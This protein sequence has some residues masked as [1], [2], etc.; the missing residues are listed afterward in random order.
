MSLTTPTMH[1]AISI[2]AAIACVVVLATIRARHRLR[3]RRLPPG[4][5]PL[6]LIGNTHQVDPSYPWLSFTQWKAPYGDL[7]YCNVLGQD[8]VIVNSEKVAEDLMEKRSRN[9]SDRMDMSDM[10]EPYGMDF[11]TVLL[12]HNATWQ[13]H[14][15]ILQQT[16]RPEVV[17]AYQSTQLHCTA[18]LT[19]SLARAPS[20]WWK[21]IRSFSAAIVIGTIYDHELP[22]NPEHDVSFKA[23]LDGS[24]LGVIIASPGPVALVK[25]I[26]LVKQLPTWMPGGQ[27][28]NAAACK[29]VFNKMVG[30]PFDEL[31]G[32]IATGK[33]GPCVAA[34]ALAKFQDT[35]KLENAEQVVKD[36]CG[37]AYSAGEETT[38]STLI[39]FTLAMVLYPD[40]Q[41]RAQDEIESIVGSSR[42]PDFNDRSA[43]PYIEAVFR[44]TLRW[45]P[46]VPLAIPH[47]AANEDVY[48]GYL[49]PKGAVIMPNLWAMSQDSTKYPSPETFNPERFLDATG[50]LTTDTPNFAFGFGRRVCPGRH[51]ASGSVW[52]AIAQ[53]LAAFSIEKAKDA[54]GNVIE[55]NP[56]WKRG[57]S[58]Y[59]LPFPCSFVPRR[60]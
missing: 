15:R 27:W 36:V 13:A 40:I 7:V 37:T 59:P 9:Y 38:G 43:L 1:S 33:A 18:N 14:R 45:R 2:S 42:L 55:P 28:F 52:I 34:D 4:P 49:I 53:I 24:E 10:L 26:P 58:S 56:G 41:K 6:P 31:L 51:L 46:V 35:K 12:N 8:I 25:A 39:V 54:A 44:E 29:R 17:V 47:V 30:T 50:K 11:A 32:R 48:D 23:V 19:Q 57:L 20:E 21:H 5:P 3:R 22:E 16:L 60:H